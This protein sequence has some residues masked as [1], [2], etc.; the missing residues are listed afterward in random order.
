MNLD[1]I[2]SPTPTQFDSLPGTFDLADAVSAALGRIPP[3]WPLRHFVAVN[4]FLG[5]RDRP[6]EEACALLRRVVGSAPVQSANEYL[7]AWRDGTIESADLEAACDGSWN[8]AQLLDALEQDDGDEEIGLI[9][10]VA[11]LLDKERPSAHWSVFVVDEI[12]R[13]CAVAFDENQTTWKSPWAREGLYA[14]WREAAPHDHNPEAFGLAGFRAFVRQLPRDADGCIAVCVERIAPPGID[15]PDFLHRQLAT[16]AGWA[17]HA[18][19]LV[20]E[21]AMR[22]RS[23]TALRDLLAIRLAYDVALFNAVSDDPVFLAEWGAAAG[24]ADTSGTNDALVRWQFAYEAGYQRRLA[25]QLAA[26]PQAPPAGRPPVQAIFCIDVRSE[27]FRRHLEASLP[28]AQTIGF[29]GFFGFPVAHRSSATAA[30]GARCPALLVPSVETCEPLPE[31][32]A[33]AASTARAE[34]GAWQA[35]QNSATSCFS[36]VET[37]GLAFVAPLMWR[38][39]RSETARSPVRPAFTEGN[40]ASL[41]SRTDMAEGA[42]RN[43]GLT[44]NFARLVLVCGHGARSA[45]NPYASSLDCGACGGHAGDVNARLAAGTLNDPAVRSRLSAR[46]I[47]IPEDTVFIAGLH[48]TTTDAVVLFDPELVPSSHAGDLARIQAALASAGTATRRERA[49]ALGLA[50]VPDSGL[51]NLLRARAADISEVRPEWG[52]ANNAALIAAPRSRTAALKLDGRTFLHDYDAANDP[53]G[54][55]LTL[56]LCAPVVVAS[57]INLQYYASRV[58]PTRYGSG[59]KT[60]HNV[61]GGIG[62]FEGNG[63][64]LKTGLPLQSIHDGNRFVHEPRRLSV[65]IAAPRQRIQAVLSAQSDVRSL[66]DHG[67]IHLFSLEDQECHRYGPDGWRRIAGADNRE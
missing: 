13:W 37:V 52:L 67:W 21:D 31:G 45:N 7:A 10:T 65:F 15:L 55:I 51:E 63:G 32:R 53:D 19:Y 35:F 28:G 3:L 4:P 36:F 25:G 9:P 48:D 33:A 24:P 39:R 17:G 18:Q 64:D 46:G 29:A 1:T 43:M 20:R 54:R 5:L 58:D 8:A 47:V 23:N 26:Q 66:F 2:P 11:D 42:L 14:A 60:L 12:S 62:V 61:V 59:D 50:E 27:V 49:P 38:S 41:A 56:I 44:R 22:G 16:I 34:A 57:W 6:F 40:A 30:V